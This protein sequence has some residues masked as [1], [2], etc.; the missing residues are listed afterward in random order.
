MA[1]KPAPQNNKAELQQ[2]KTEVEKLRRENN[3]IQKELE[4]TRTNLFR[5]KTILNNIPDI[6]WYKD[7]SSK[8][9][10]VNKAYLRSCGKTAEE[11]KGKTDMDL[12]PPPLAQHYMSIDQ[13][14][15][16]T[17]KTIKIEE[18][19]TDSEEN[20]SWIETIK[21]P[22]FNEAGDII[23]TAGIARDITLRKQT[24]AK[25]EQSCEELENRIKE[26]TATLEIINRGL[27]AEVEERKQ[28]EE[29]LKRE[30]K[31]F[32]GGPVVV[33]KKKAEPGWPVE[34]V[35]PNIAQ[36]GY[37]TEDF[38]KREMLYQDIIFEKDRERVLGEVKKHCDSGVVYFEQDYRISAF[39]GEIKWVYD[40][41]VIIRN[42]QGRVT[43]F[44]GFIL[45]ITKR[46]KAL[47]ALEES[48]ARFKL[49]ADYTTAAEVFRNKNGDLVY[50]SP[51]FKRITGY[52]PEEY[53]K[54]M[55]TY[56]DMLV[57][58]QDKTIENLVQ[59]VVDGKSFEDQEVKIHKKNGQVA[60]ISISSQPVILEDGSFGGTR[61]SFREITRKKL[62]NEIQST[63]EKIYNDILTFTDDTVTVFDTSG[64]II[65][66]TASYDTQQENQEGKNLRE[67][68]HARQAK[69]TIAHI[70]EVVRKDIAVETEIKTKTPD[71]TMW[72][73][74]HFF[75]IKQDGHTASVARVR[76]DI[77]KLKQKYE[78][79]RKQNKLLNKL[80]E[81][82]PS[83]VFWL[84][85][86]MLITGCNDTFA[87]LYNLNTKKLPIPVGKFLSGNDADILTQA[88]GK[89]FKTNT[90]EEDIKISAINTKGNIRSFLSTLIPINDHNGK[91]MF[92]LGLNTDVTELT[93]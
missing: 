54:G 74:E 16:R 1:H 90:P 48:K 15:I 59:L 82:I 6:A 73:S 81:N 50:A 9:L 85:T 68:Y 47:M 30:R 79:L 88:A 31:L 46:K 52:E 58:G 80:V 77:T 32:I 76:R 33:F 69:Q 42:A 53:L 19:F 3:Q 38:L 14:V 12:F 84:N 89:I 56:E 43:H 26:R 91:T 23:G 37:H 2:L 18:E 62:A 75:P 65:F 24:E 70:N 20:Q 10:A 64:N 66:D 51:A 49:I 71:G 83:P 25:Y 13:E 28:I 60:Y 5:Y 4:K 35:S 86:K 67:I 17:A 34:Y 57:K 72:Y 40:F 78:K 22:V 27:H 11:I 63:R 45:D 87:R 39:G 44:D 8:L 36:F 61:T 21:S 55:L 93:S 7:L 41:S 92:V 29:A